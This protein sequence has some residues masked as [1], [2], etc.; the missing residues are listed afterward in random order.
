[1]NIYRGIIFKITHE[2]LDYLTKNNTAIEELHLSQCH[3]VTDTGIAYIAERLHRLKRLY[4]QVRRKIN[5]SC[6]FQNNRVI[7]FILLTGMFAVNRSHIG[8]Y[9]DALYYATIFG[10]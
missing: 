5:S 4:L 9:K 10:R 7:L 8:R 6:D 3:N 1:M 2:G